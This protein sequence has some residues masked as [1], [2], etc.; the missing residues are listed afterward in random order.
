[1]L[2]HELADECSDGFIGYG[3]WL[4]RVPVRAGKNGTTGYPGV[5]RRLG[6]F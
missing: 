1:M 2:G 3:C 5:A 4:G 6:L